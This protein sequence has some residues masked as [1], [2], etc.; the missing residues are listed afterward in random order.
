MEG[1][2]QIH[3]GPGGKFEPQGNYSTSPSDID[4]LL[5]VLTADTRPSITIHFHGGL[6]RE[7]KGVAIAEM[8]AP[9]YQAANSYPIS[10]V[11]ETGLIE[12]FRDNFQKLHSTK[13][14]NKLVKWVAKRVAKRFGGLNSKGV[15]EPITNAEVEEE[16]KKLKPFADYDAAEPAK[17]AAQR[18]EIAVTEDDLDIVREELE[19]EF[20]EDLETDDEI[21]E[22]IAEREND[23]PVDS[24]QKGVWSTLKLARKLAKIAYRVI[25]R[26]LK[27]R[28]HGLHCTVV[29]EV[30]REYYLAD[31]GAW[32]WGNMKLKAEAMWKPNEGLG[33]QDLHVGHYFL[34]MLRKLQ[35]VRPDL[36]INLVGHS[37]GTI[38]ICN[39]LHVIDE[40]YPAIKIHKIVFM[41]AAARSDLTVSEIAKHEERYAQFFH[42]TMS[43]HYEQ[44]D[45]LAPYVYSRSLLYLISGVLEPDEVD[46]P[47]AGMMRHATG[48]KPFDV[49]AA[50][51][52]QEFIE[53]LG[54]T[55]LSDSSVLDPPAVEGRRCSAVK[56][57]DFDNDAM[58]QE[59]LA[60][61]LAS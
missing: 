40:H 23:Q 11:W 30:V 44:N 52:W 59:S 45:I 9:V 47:L 7:D 26:H 54:R 35:T 20:E 51:D 36:K 53:R 18:G 27:D 4:D 31:L 10:F 22:L 37:A 48:S 41:A 33:G 29:E 15:G 19:A 1:R 12:T 21:A 3:V 6:V 16:L 2:S 61:I 55:V 13:L 28:D 60:Q 34:D 24:S 49:G 50:K 39:M 42:Y 58:M 38:A 25:R 32:V 46:V 14:F 5:A 8:I 57:G 56:H 43:D 17:G